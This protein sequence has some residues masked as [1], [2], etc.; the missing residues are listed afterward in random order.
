MVIKILALTDSMTV[1]DN[2]VANDAVLIPTGTALTVEHV[3]KLQRAG[4]TEICVADT[5]KAPCGKHD[6]PISTYIAESARIDTLFSPYSFDEQMMAMK[7][8]ILDSLARD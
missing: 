1:G 4:I 8:A 7:N 3:R 5:K 2:V 6:G